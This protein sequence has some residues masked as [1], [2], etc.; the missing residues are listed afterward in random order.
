LI[1]IVNPKRPASRG[2]KFTVAEYQKKAIYAM[3]EITKRNKIPIICG[4]T[5]FYIDAITKGII[6]PEVPPNEKLRKTLYS[7]SAIALFE[8]LE[9]LDKNRAQD[10]KNKNEQNNKVRLIRAIEI[11]KTLGKTPHLAVKPLSYKFI[12][13]GLYLP[14]DELKKRVEKRVKKMFQDGLLNEIKKLKKAGISQKRLKE[15]GFEYYNPTYK[16]DAK[17]QMTWFKRDKTIR[18]LDLSRHSNTKAEA[19]KKIDLGCIL[20][21][22]KLL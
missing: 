12:K 19:S 10:I 4:G 13:I 16:K 15:F 5:G 3:A 7:K 20:K 11:A 22:F 21:S 6:F 17:R 18:W 14:P 9:K 1:N 8:Y 2:G